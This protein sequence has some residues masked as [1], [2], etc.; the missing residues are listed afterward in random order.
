MCQSSN[1][2]HVGQSIHSMCLC[3][4]ETNRHA[5]FRLNSGLCAVSK[6]LSSPQASH[7]V[8]KSGYLAR[9]LF[10]LVSFRGLRSLYI[11]RISGFRRWKS[12]LL[13]RAAFIAHSSEQ[14]LRLVLGGIISKWL[15]QIAQSRPSLVKSICS[16]LRRRPARAAHGCEHHFLSGRMALNAQPQ[17]L[18]NKSYIRHKYH[19]R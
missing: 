7:D 2:W 4:F 11:L 12:L 9:S 16:S 10:N 17:S 5:P 3:E 19:A 14:Y 1:L 18:Q 6:T 13:S 8:G 15:P